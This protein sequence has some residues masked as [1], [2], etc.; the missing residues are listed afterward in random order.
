[1]KFGREKHLEQYQGCFF[2]RHGLKNSMPLL[3]LPLN[4]SHSNRLNRM[5]YV[6]YLNFTYIR[7]SEVLCK[8]M[9]SCPNA[10]KKL[11]PRSFFPGMPHKQ[12]T[13]LRSFSPRK[14]NL[15]RGEISK[16]QSTSKNYGTSIHAEV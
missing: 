15:S 5:C 7:R 14:V 10:A 2:F 13:M 8:P 12:L 11:C 16:S 4:E 9:I 6:S 1:M 3:K